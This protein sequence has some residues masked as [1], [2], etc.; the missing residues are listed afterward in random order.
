MLALKL[1]NSMEVELSNAY[2]SLQEMKED[3]N[4]IIVSKKNFCK[5]DFSDKMISFIYSSLIKFVETNK[6]KGI[7]MTKNFID[8]LKGIMNNDLNN[9]KNLLDKTLVNVTL[10]VHSAV[11]LTGTKS[12]V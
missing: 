7:L 6:V 4:S 11:A 5:S 3:I 12:N 10:Q 1:K 8:N 9:F 2:C